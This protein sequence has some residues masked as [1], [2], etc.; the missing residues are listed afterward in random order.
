VN[1]LKP[2][3]AAAALLGL[4]AGAS[5]AETATAWNEHPNSRVR[6]IAGEDGTI[7]VELQLAPGWKTY[8]RMPGDAGV[9]PSFDWEGSDNA[10]GFDVLYPAP[11]SMS[12]QGGTAVGYK[13][14]VI[15]PVR[16]DREAGKATKIAL[17]FSFGVCKDV[18]IPVDSK[19]SFTLP[20]TVVRPSPAQPSPA[21][22]AA[23]ALV[24]RPTTEPGKAM[25]ALVSSAYDLTGAAPHITF[26]TRGAADVFIEAPDGL[27]VPLTQMKDEKDGVATY[28]ADLSKSPDVKDLAGKPLRV[29]ITAPNAAGGTETTLLLK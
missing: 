18:C 10:K 26:R 22:K 15:F 2:I 7:G 29:T 14:H 1:A 23:V 6:L 17:E 3:I 8:W 5:Y 11:I 13:G 16:L 9:P 19:L 20:P 24:P 21:L 27:F 4:S 28:V 12:D 25:P